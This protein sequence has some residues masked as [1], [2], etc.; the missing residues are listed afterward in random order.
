M[1]VTAVK[2]ER[3]L[4][5]TISIEALLDKYLPEISEGTVVAVASKVV[6]VCE[7]RVVPR[8]NANTEDLTKQESSLYLPARINPYG[9]T[10]SVAR[11]ELVARAGIDDSNSG[12]YVVLWPKDTQLSAN[13]IREFLIKKFG[14]KKVGV[15]L[16]DSITRPLQ[17][18]VTGTAISYSGF[19]PLKNYI[20]TEDLFGRKL[21]YQT[22]SIKNGLAAAAAL[23][24]GEGD[25]QTPLAI[26]EDLPFVEFQKG[27]PT[28]EEMASL[29]ISLE[30]DL[31]KLFLANVPWEKGDKF[32]G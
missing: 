13:R 22:S 6:A 7:G 25:E 26:I 1:K 28:H 20:G 16:T 32:Q 30:E 5:N 11:N 4:P 12:E 21:E 27:N 15:V 19:K 3:I 29:K 17:W 2:T 14:V 31:Y 18:G 8:E 10:L 9:V 24:M 23:V